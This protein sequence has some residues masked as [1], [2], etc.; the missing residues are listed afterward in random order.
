MNADRLPEPQIEP[1]ESW[2]RHSAP[3][4]QFAK[5]MSKC[6]N[7]SG[8]CSRRGHCVLGGCFDSNPVHH[9]LAARIEAL[10]T[11]ARSNG[12]TGSAE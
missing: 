2:L 3:H 12:W 11:W 8:D 4:D 6:Q 7:S 1:R 5:A 10:E 9:D